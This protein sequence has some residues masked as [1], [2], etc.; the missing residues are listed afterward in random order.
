MLRFVRKLKAIRCECVVAFAVDFDY[1]HNIM[2]TPTH[3]RVDLRLG[4][5]MTASNKSNTHRYG[6]SKVF[7]RLRIDVRAR[8]Y[9]K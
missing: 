9:V 3:E 5:M 4:R 2:I 6:G 8:K 7:I 1:L